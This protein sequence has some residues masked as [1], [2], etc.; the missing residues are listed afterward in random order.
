MKKLFLGVH[1]QGSCRPSRSG[2]V[3][4]TLRL[5]MCSSRSTAAPGPRFH[6]MSG[7]VGVGIL[8]V[9]LRPAILPVISSA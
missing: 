5:R 3:R 8:P 4:T 1:V 6:V 7:V 9:A 2:R